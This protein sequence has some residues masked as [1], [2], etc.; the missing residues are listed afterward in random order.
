L[1][2]NPDRRTAEAL[3]GYGEEY[4]YVNQIIDQTKLKNGNAMNLFIGKSWKFYKNNSYLRLG[5]NVNNLL[6]NT[7]FKT[8]GFEQLR[9]DASNI[10]RFPNKYGYMYGRTYFLMLSYLY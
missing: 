4:P 1:S 7:K 10:Q 6:D 3:A 8:G 9:Y 5:L 2:P